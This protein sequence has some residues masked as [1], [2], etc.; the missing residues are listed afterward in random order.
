[1]CVCVFREETSKTKLKTKYWK[2][3]K[4]EEGKA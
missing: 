1:M 3:E 4:K 2:F